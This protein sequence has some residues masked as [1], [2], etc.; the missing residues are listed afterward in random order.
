MP[1]SNDTRGEV[2]SSGSAVLA[3]HCFFCFQVILAQLNG[4]PEPHPLPFPDA[5][6]EYPLFVTWNI[7]STP[8][9]S[10][11]RLRGCIGTFEPYP[12]A[13]GLS[14]YASVSAFKDRRFNPISAKEVARL[15]CGVSLL[16]AFEECQDHLDWEV[17]VHGIYIHLPNPALAPAAGD[18]S[19]SS[20]SGSS[21]PAPT[22]AAAAAAA[23]KRSASSSSAHIL[24]ATYLPDVIPDQGWSKVEAI[25][26]AI[27]KA[28]WNGRI[29]DATRRSL[30]VRRY[31]S[32]KMAKTY[33]DF[34][35]W[36][37]QQQQQRQA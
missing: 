19:A 11:P 22:A 9:T 26:S 14:E 17:G 15:E 34:V 5:G 36:Q 8:F 13:E 35:A 3:E 16:T 33:R 32:E 25:D 18:D 30:R 10:S 1:S 31:R 20:S 24:T 21:T 6:Q 29:T 23:A 37:Q 7:Y 28:G 27:R 12:L 2:A 4:E